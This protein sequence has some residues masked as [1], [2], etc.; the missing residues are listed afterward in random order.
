[1]FGQWEWISNVNCSPTSCRIMIGW[2][3][4]MVRLMVINMS[5]QAVLCSMEIVATK[6]KFYCNF[7]YASNSG[8]ERRIL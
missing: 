2:N 5:K 4:V 8:I 6:V 1:M 3:P 7:V